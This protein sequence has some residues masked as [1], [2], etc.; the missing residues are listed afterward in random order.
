MHAAQVQRQALVKDHVRQTNA[1][2]PGIGILPQDVLVAEEDVLPRIQPRLHGR[3]IPAPRAHAR[4]L[5]LRRPAGNHLRVHG[6][7]PVHMIPVAVGHSAQIRLRQTGC[8]Q[9]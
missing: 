4:Q 3:R 2:L 7:Q 1:D 9:R 8:A 6:V 5:R